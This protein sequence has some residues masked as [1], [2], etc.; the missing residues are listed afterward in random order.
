MRDTLDF[1]AVHWSRIALD[2]AASEW[3]NVGNPKFG[4]PAPLQGGPPLV[5]NGM[6]WG[7]HLKM[8]ENKWVTDFFL[9]SIS[10]VMGPYLYLVGAHLVLCKGYMQSI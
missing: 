2:R 6:T 1:R 5:I 10:G 3:E 7:P 8:V 4:S 9:T